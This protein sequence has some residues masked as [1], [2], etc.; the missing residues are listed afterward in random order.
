MQLL[1]G[2]WGIAPSDLPKEPNEIVAFLDN[3]KGHAPIPSWVYT[4]I[5]MLTEEG[6]PVFEPIKIRMTS[7][8]YLFRE[9]LTLDS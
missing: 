5:G 9:V 1:F 6:N 2:G 8:N 3:F 7:L 4:S